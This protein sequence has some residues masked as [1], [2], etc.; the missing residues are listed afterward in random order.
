MRAPA[1]LDDDA[2]RESVARGVDQPQRAA[3]PPDH[4]EPQTA[5]ARRFDRARRNIAVGVDHRRRSTREQL[6]KQAQL[7]VEIGF[8]RR[9]IIEVVARQ[10]GEG[11][12]GEPHPVEPLLI[13]AVRGGFKR[14]MGDADAGEFVER[15]VQRDRIGRRQRAVDFE[16][17]RDD[18]ERA[19]RSGFATGRHP[20]LPSESGDG[21]L[22]AGAGDGD[23]A[24]GLARIEAR[25]GLGERRARVDDL[26]EGRAACRRA[27]ADDDRR[28]LGE[29]VGD[30]GEAVLFGPGEGEKG[31][32]GPHLAAVGGQPADRTLGHRR[33]ARAEVE[34]FV[35]PLH[36]LPIRSASPPSP[37]RARIGNGW[38]GKWSAGGT[39]SSGSIRVIRF[40]V[41]RPALW[42]AVW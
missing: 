39:P 36:S 10:V 2:R 20:D 24:I 3:A 12:G 40:P 26:D 30:K 19:E 34:N 23:D 31:V 29:R 41:V 16:R 35:K 25:R 15:L 1:V 9:V 22:A 27:L 17:A 32:A 21:S 6:A 33:F 5:R 13:E 11:A 4:V 42:A 8:L 14:E 28:A 37:R 7:G 18:A 38:S